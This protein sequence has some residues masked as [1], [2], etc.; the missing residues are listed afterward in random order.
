M[1]LT[2][3]LTLGRSGL[4]VSP[5][6]LGAMTFGNGENWTC[7]APS[8]RKI[9]HSFLESG[10]NFIDTADVYTE[11]N[12]E[13]IIG[14]TLN[15]AGLR[16]Q[17]V[18]ATKYTF[19]SEAP[20]INGLGNG[21]KNAWRALDDSL[22]RLNTDYVDLYWMHAW[23]CVTPLEEIVQT[24]DAMVRSGKIRYYGLSNVPAWF[25]ARLCDFA[26]SHGF[27]RPIALQLEYSLV[28]RIAEREHLPAAKALGLGLCPW[29]PLAGGALTGKYKSGETNEGR[30]NQVSPQSGLLADDRVWRIVKVL[31]DV[32]E[33]L[34]R[35][36][37]EVAL[38]WAATRFPSTSVILGASRPE[39]LEQNIK[40][41]AFEIPDDA[42]ASLEL[43]SRLRLAAPYSMFL[44][45]TRG[46]IMGQFRGWGE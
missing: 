28:E 19:G 40:S 46:R 2:D 24:F 11:G 29:S 39:Q 35:S 34:G 31:V 10:G 1:N 8:S 43:A 9:M 3:Y 16:E 5:L 14:A 7:D 33:K 37:A 30:L 23:D 21:R 27:A 36:P 18:I 32:A 45:K 38:N 22:R 42:L 41:L 20:G 12:S 6:C 25:T 13:R 26:D 4:R 44:K 15:E 17:V